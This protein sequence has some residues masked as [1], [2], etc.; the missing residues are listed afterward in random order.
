MGRG[1]YAGEAMELLDPIRARPGV[2]GILTDFDGTLSPIAPR[3]E[4]ARPV[5]G[6]S[7]GLAALAERYAVVAV[8]SGRR[9]GEVAGLLDRP[10]G[11]RCF[12]LYGLEDEDGPVDPA[13]AGMVGRIQEVLPE[14]ERTASLVPG[15]RV[16]PKALH[17]AVHYRGAAD[18]QAARRVLVE[19]LGA[20]AGRYGFRIVEGKKV[21]ELAPPEGPTKGDVVDRVTEDGALRTVLYAGDD[22]ADVDAFAAVRRLA[23]RG[24]GGVTVAVRSSEAPVE[25]IAA[26][27]V[28]VDDPAG[29]VRLFRSLL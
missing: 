28:L 27:D 22:L 19:G 12:G 24:I 14:V 26:A 11:V 25:L 5:D 8:V 21:V 13:A 29:L 2:A 10:P 17:V 20:V 1:G 23:E 7:G 16:E 4:D 15:S 18:P 3:P 9:A 6:A